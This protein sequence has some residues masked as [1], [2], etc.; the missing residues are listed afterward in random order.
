MEILILEDEEREIV[1]YVMWY[2]S[3]E[4]GASNGGRVPSIADTL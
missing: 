4:G 1:R 3:V 2:A